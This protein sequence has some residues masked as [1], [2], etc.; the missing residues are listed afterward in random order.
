MVVGRITKK[1]ERET[2]GEIK[3]GDIRIDAY[4]LESHIPEAHEKELIQLGIDPLAYIKYIVENFTEI[5]V[6]SA[7]SYMLVC[8]HNKPYLKNIA[9]VTLEF[10]YVKN[11]KGENY[12][13]LV[14]TAQPRPIN[15]LEKRKLLWS[16]K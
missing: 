9:A 1:I 6:G 10:A 15:R 5:R 3:S 12:Y 8:P 2:N 13:W 11:N 7:K 16:K 14:R 4:H